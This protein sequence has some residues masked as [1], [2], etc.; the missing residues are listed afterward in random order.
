MHT[1]R[2]KFHYVT[3]IEIQKYFSKKNKDIEM[4]LCP[5][6]WKCTIYPEYKYFSWCRMFSLLWTSRSCDPSWTIDHDAALLSSL[7]MLIQ[8]IGHRGP[9]IESFL[10]NVVIFRYQAWAH[11]DSIVIRLNQ[12]QTGI[13]PAWPIRAEH[14]LCSVIRLLCPDHIHC[15]H[16]VS[17]I[18]HQR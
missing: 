6:Q 15:I 2:S 18:N 10:S 4:F 17:N 9:G 11:S 8:P 3:R 13:T 14:A 7:D 16:S 1:S 5:L 12:S